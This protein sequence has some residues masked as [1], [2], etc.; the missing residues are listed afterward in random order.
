MDLRLPSSVRK[1]T[2]LQQGPDGQVTPVVVYR[3]T[4]KNKKKQ[5]RL[6]KPFEKAVRQF[7]KAERTW[8]QS[9][10]DRHDESNRSRRDGWV[11]DVTFNVSKAAAKAGRQL[12][13]DRWLIT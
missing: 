4:Q 8:A 3:S 1:V 2:V 5:T 6:L 7:A 10:L 13:L 12:R 11:R 9:Y